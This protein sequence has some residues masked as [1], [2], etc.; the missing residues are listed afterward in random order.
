M[1]TQPKSHKG[2]VLITGTSTGIGHATALYLD[3][4]GFRVFATVREERD[5]AALRAQAS[6]RLM[7]VYMDVTSVRS[8]E[9][10]RSRISLAVGADGLVGLV[11]NAGADFEA[12]LECVPLDWV[13]WLFEVNVF[14]LLSVTQAFLPLVRQAHG[15]I[16]NVSSVATLI[17]APLYGHYAATKLSVN[18]LSD[19]LRLELKPSG[20]QVCTIVPGTVKT[21]FWQ[22][23]TNITEHVRQA[24]PPEA[25]ERYGKAFEPMRQRLAEQS[26]RGA[27]PEQVA[28]TIAQALTNRRAKPYYLVGRQMQLIK[29]ITA[30]TSH[31]MQDRLV[32][33][34]FALPRG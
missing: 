34:V 5:A 21:M 30:L 4:L 23:L 15:R 24:E 16:V 28:R 20:V 12:P 9:N 31:S 32:A 13:R 3:H 17:N 18:A 1:R 7:P 14:G 29:L 19:A 22:N 25:A 33:R 27:A 10:A 11:N 6:D 8:I 26:K 2:N